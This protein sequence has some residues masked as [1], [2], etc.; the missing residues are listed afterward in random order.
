MESSRERH[1]E[2][3]RRGNMAVWVRTA[4]AMAL[5]ANC[6]RKCVCVSVQWCLDARLCKVKMM[7]SAKMLPSPYITT[8]HPQIQS[9]RTYGE[10]QRSSMLK[11]LIRVFIKTSLEWSEANWHSGLLNWWIMSL[12]MF[13]KETKKRDEK[14]QRMM[15]THLQHL[16]QSTTVHLLSTNGPTTIYTLPHKLQAPHLEHVSGKLHLEQSSCKS[17]CIDLHFQ[18]KK[19]IETLSGRHYPQP[20]LQPLRKCLL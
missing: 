8:A 17:R 3:G 11:K 16:L 2:L 14:R 12:G 20:P 1:L 18:L 7:T 5:I 6:R 19:P 4:G 13:E 9:S 10:C 15:M